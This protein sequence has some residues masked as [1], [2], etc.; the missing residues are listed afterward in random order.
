MSS[1]AIIAL[2]RRLA[3]IAGVAEAEFPQPS[4]MNPA[5]FRP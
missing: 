4:R 5:A 2:V 1:R 3:G